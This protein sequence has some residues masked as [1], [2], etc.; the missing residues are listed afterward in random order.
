MLKMRSN[1]VGV[2]A[3][4]VDAEFELAI[5]GLAAGDSGMAGDPQQPALALVEVKAVGN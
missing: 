3:I 5:V 1:P 2:V 4:G